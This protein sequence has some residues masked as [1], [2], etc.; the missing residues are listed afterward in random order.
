MMSD[1]QSAYE[2]R[3]KF[4]ER[5]V[6]TL[7]ET[8]LDHFAQ[9]ALASGRYAASQCYDIANRAMEARKCIPPSKI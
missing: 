6:R 5:Q 8:L 9:S 2:S 3:I 7:E 4:L 1:D